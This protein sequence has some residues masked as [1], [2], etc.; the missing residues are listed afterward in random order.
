MDTI[1]SEL[2]SESMTAQLGHMVELLEGASTHAHAKADLPTLNAVKVSAGEGRIKAVATD[3]Y[4]LIEGTIEGEGELE[5][6]LISLTDIK[7]VL[8]LLKG[9]GK[10]MDTLPV[11]LSRVG[12]MLTV[13]V[14][15][16]AVTITLLGGTYPPTDEHLACDGED[17]PLTN[18]G[19]NPALMA[20]Y[21][22]IAGRGSKSAIGVRLVFKGDRKPIK[23][24]M[25]VNS[26]R[27]VEW[28]AVIMPMRWSDK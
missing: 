3:R 16:N 5:P 24:E 14:R 27:K 18:I 12:D 9:E 22:K 7:R 26:S 17:I 11:T 2:K 8:T 1:K 15:G 4:R 6:S 23:V 20:D 13:L 19:F 25:A 10:R 28:R 21:A